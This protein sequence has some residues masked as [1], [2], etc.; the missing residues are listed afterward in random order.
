MLE[1]LEPEP[2]RNKIIL[3]KVKLLLEKDIPIAD[4]TFYKTVFSKSDPEKLLYS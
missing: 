4:D 2:L 3:E 1:A